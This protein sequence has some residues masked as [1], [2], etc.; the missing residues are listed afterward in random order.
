MR[1]WL[2]GWKNASGSEDEASNTE[3][4]NRDIAPSN[5]SPRGP[6]NTSGSGIEPQASR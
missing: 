6:Q 3:S 4:T 5:S 2:S 1:S